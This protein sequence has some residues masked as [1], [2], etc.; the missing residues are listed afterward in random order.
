LALPLLLGQI[1]ASLSV[2]ASASPAVLALPAIGGASASAPVGQPGMP[3]PSLE[4]LVASAVAG[5][6]ASGLA[7]WAKRWPAI[8]FIT[9]DTKGLIQILIAGFSLTSGALTAY[10]AGQIQGF[11][12]RTG[13]Q[14]VLYAIISYSA[15]LQAYQ[16]GIKQIGEAMVT[17][18]GKAGEPIQPAQGAGD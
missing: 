8:K 7:E 13:I 1:P 3:V 15:A 9:A 6:I 5:I 11:D 18:T 4:G 14:A 2:L 12:W 16:G 10:A 17:A